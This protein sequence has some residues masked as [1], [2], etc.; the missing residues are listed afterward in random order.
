MQ[1]TGTQVF[2]VAQFKLTPVK[3]SYL[4]RFH[5]SPA[6]VLVTFPVYPIRPVHLTQLDVIPVMS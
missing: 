1:S 6:Y 5:D 2:L 4:F 3:W